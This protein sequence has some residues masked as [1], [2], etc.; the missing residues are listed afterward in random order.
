M[1]VRGQLHAP[2]TLPPE[3]VWTFLRREKSLTAAGIPT[4]DPPVFSDKGHKKSHI[5]SKIMKD[6]RKCKKNSTQSCS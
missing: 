3:P 1:E 5:V 2:A 6:T 4:L